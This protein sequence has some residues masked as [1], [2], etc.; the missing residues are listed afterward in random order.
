MRSL[1]TSLAVAC[2]L[3]IAPSGV[4]AQTVDGLLRFKPVVAGVEYDIPAD[5]PAVAACKIEIISKNGSGYALRDGQGQLLRKFVDTNQVKD[6]SGK[7]NLDQWS[8][9]KDGFEVYRELDLNE[10]KKLDECRWMNSGGTRIAVMSGGA[11][12]AWKR[13]SAEEASKVLVQ[14]LLA[15]DPALLET[16]MATPAE[17]TALGVPKG[18]VDQAAAATETRKGKLKDLVTKLGWSDQTTW[19]GLNGQM[20]HLLPADAGL[21]DDLMVYENAMISASKGTKGTEE[22]YLLVPELV[23]IGETWKFVALPAAVKPGDGPIPLVDASIRSALYREAAPEVANRD[24]KMD[25]AL[26]KLADYDAAKSDLLSSTDV[27]EVLAYHYNRIPL[28]REVSKVAPAEEKINFDRQVANAL[29][30]GVATGKFPE[31]IKYLD[32]L[33]AEKGKI[34]SYAALRKIGA[35]YALANDEA[36]ATPVAVQ[37]KWLGDLKAFLEAYP[38]SDEVPDALYQLAWTSE[39]N[40]DEDEAKLYYARLAKDF[41]DTTTGKKAAGALRRLD[42]VG[43]PFDLKGTGLTGSPVDLARF[44]GKTVLVTFWA[45]WSGDVKRETPELLKVYEAHKAQ[46]FEIVGVNLDTEKADLEAFLKE[47]PTPWAQIFEPGGLEG[48]LAQEFGI[49]ALPT[50]ILVSPEG[51]VINR[52]MRL[53]SQVEAQLDKVLGAGGKGVALGPK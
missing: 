45:T 1:K 52:G 9:Y 17:L 6:A 53:V 51:K 47:V 3:G 37:K 7:A 27:K 30:E 39:V 5:P 29:A 21:K 33:I 2:L 25:E 11:I 4:F 49:F 32:G 38:K 34:G 40:T 48:R 26:K 35:E 42:L 28:L 16:V 36:G 20:P 44:K 10:D 22:S 19:S 41:P 50:M 31:G 43:K 18:V 46:G 8:Y 15:G 14:A 23:K 13:I 12:Q 24:P